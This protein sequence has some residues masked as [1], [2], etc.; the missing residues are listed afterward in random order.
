MLNRPSSST[1]PDRPGCYLFRDER[2]RVIYVG[3]ALSL[4]KRLSNYFGDPA[5]LHARTAAMVEQA[6]D[7]EWIVAANEVESLHLEYNLIKQHSPRF[8]VRYRDDKSY[9]FLAITWGEEYP[10]AMVMRG[11]KKKGVR[12]FGPYAHAYAI[13][14][15]LDLLLRTF[16]MRTCS[17]GV[18]DRARRIK[19]PCLMY[20]IGKCAAPCTG[21]IDADG[22]RR[23]AEELCA[24]VGGRTDPVVKRL[25]SEMRDAATREEFE[26]AARLRDQLTSVRKAIEKQVAVTDSNASFDAID[27]AEDDLEAAVQVFF[28]RHGRITGRKG[29][30]VDKV[31]DLAPG[32]LLAG[33]VRDLYMDGSEV[34][35]EILVPSLPADMDVLK[36]WLSEQRT[37]KVD[38]HVP[39]RG[40]R[41][42]LLETVGQ[43]AREAFVQ[44]KLKRRKDFEARA[45]A[46]R[47]LQDELNLPDAPLRIECFDI[48]N[49]GP[50]E[51]VGSMV[52]F[53][54][55][56]P[57][58]SDYRKFKIKSVTG[59]DD[60][61]SMHEVISRRFARARTED[62]DAKPRKFAYPPNLLVIDG[63]KGQLNAALAAMSELGVQDVTAVG[64]AKR[65]EEVYL[66]EKPEPVI[67]P[68]GSDALYLLQHI[69]DE[70]HRFAITYHRT[71]RNK[72]TTASALD[73]IPGIGPER[74]RILLRKFG[75][76]RRILQASENDLAQVVPANV[77]GRIHAYLRGLGG[78]E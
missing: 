45:K 77:A 17:Q 56:L 72:K 2:H 4:R 36:K 20:D 29:F 70:A 37:A 59:Q 23:V 33:F 26:R 9:P 71:L 22:H 7:V 68:R 28:I 19:R 12:Y 35:P 38:F 3:K 18:F 14:E 31:E 1:I 58:R 10:R 61:A 6:R 55:G 8:N 64:L 60:F 48:S 5:S 25:E 57:K 74:K 66:P 62:E 78:N 54:D 49:L 13:R 50:T 27:V 44:H 75:S 67:V 21:F 51:V 16:P 41:R 63:G 32:A 52:V 43:N 40:E 34:P 69:R 42:A 76:V 53:E 24:F 47:A 73:A 11:S 15:T 65:F 30:V 46:L 39:Q